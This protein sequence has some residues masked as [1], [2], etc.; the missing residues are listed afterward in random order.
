[1]MDWYWIILLMVGWFA[2]QRWI[3]P[4]LGVST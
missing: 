2:L 1:M 4:R 3:L